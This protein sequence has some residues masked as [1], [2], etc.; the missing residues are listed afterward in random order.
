MF[1][2]QGK[3]EKLANTGS[4]HYFVADRTRNLL[5]DD[6]LFSR[7]QEIRQIWII[8]NAPDFFDQIYQTTSHQRFAQLCLRHLR[9]AF[10]LFCYK[11]LIAV[12]DHLIFLLELVERDRIVA[13]VKAP[14]FRI[15]LKSNKIVQK[16]CKMRIVFHLGDLF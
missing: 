1:H 6:I 8:I 14:N 10:L 2:S 13:D 11:F 3:L 16:S 9:C 7:S 4:P 15:S 12:V 5:N